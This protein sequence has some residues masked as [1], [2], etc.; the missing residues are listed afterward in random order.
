MPLLRND[1]DYD[2]AE[3]DALFVSTTLYIPLHVLVSRPSMRSSPRFPSTF[4]K[5]KNQ[6]AIMSVSNIL[7]PTN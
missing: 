7:T 5:D 3:T 6:S 1:D 4:Q 2:D